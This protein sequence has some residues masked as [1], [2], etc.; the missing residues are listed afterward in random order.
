MRLRA[1]GVVVALTAPSVATAQSADARR[2]AAESYDRG[3]AAYQR[4]E[5]SVA[6]DLFED[7]DR[8][9]PSTAAA[10]AALRALR[11]AGTAD[12][13]VR[14][15][16]LALDLRGRTPPDASAVSA[17]ERTLAELSPLLAHLVVQCDGC[18][19]SIDGAANTRGERYLTAGSH[20]VHAQ[21]PQGA[22][23][24]ATVDLRAGVLRQVALTVPIT[25]RAT[26][27]P[28]VTPVVTGPG[29]HPREPFQT[30]SSGLSPAVFVTGLGVTAVLGGV[31]LWSWIDT[32]SGADAFSRAIADGTA[33]QAQLDDGAN[34]ERRTTV[35]LTATGT[36]GVATLVLGV[37]FT[38]WRR[39][40]VTFVAGPGMVGVGGVL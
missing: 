10:L 31:T 37:F 9:V 6:A 38:R 11:R 8:Q 20:Q 2:A 23:R 3:S 5:F 39:A 34:R 21:W 19:V 4:R 22:S 28:T 16:N 13:L 1:I 25:P 35:L 26:P 36:L 29:A 14:A 30:Q 17:A 7:A 12:H 24:D 40:P 27:V 15:A 32:T 33:T 18:A